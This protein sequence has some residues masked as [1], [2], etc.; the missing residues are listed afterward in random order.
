MK[1]HEICVEDG[2]YSVSAQAIRCGKDI[3]LTVVGGEAPHVGASALA[4][5][6]PSLSDPEKTSASTS[7]LC[8]PGHKEDEVARRFAQCI[9]A[10]M[11]CVVSASV[12]VHID[13]AA[14]EELARLGR[15]L[16]SLLSAVI[17]RLAGSLEK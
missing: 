13:N 14:G 9:A 12:G 17:E 6:R 8:A 4:I 1:M 5:P 10:K 15:N 3:S 7:V 11:N 2:K 16:E